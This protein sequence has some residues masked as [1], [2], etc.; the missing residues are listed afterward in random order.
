MFAG[1]WPVD[2]RFKSLTSV[3]V[4]GPDPI[5]VMVN[6]RRATSHSSSGLPPNPFDAD[7]EIYAR[8]DTKQEAAATSKKIEAWLLE[9][10]KALERR[11]K[12]VKILLLGTPHLCL[13]THV[14]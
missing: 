6:R 4:L 2:K 14:F 12:G 3:H 9:G 1:L 11:R 10:K 13:F 7:P 5:F 8:S